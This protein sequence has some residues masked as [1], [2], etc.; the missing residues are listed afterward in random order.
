MTDKQAGFRA[1]KGTIGQ[2][3][4]LYELVEGRWAKGKATYCLF[5]DFKQGFDSVWRPTLEA[6]LKYYGNEEDTVQFIG[7]L[8]AN[9]EP[10]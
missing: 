2:V 7:K 9:P 3:F 1:R 4:S 8:I 10:W 5:I 6:I